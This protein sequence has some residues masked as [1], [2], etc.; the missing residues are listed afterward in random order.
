MKFSGKRILFLGTNVGSVD[1]VKYAKSHGAYT[2]V[3]DYLPEK[4]SE[5]KQICD[6]SYSISTAD[7]EGLLCLARAEKINGVLAGISEFNL[8]QA[9]RL[10]NL[11]DLPFYCNFKQWECVENKKEFRKLCL[12]FNVPTPKTYYTGNSDIEF[13]NLIYPLVVKPVDS[14]ASKGVSICNNRQECAEA[15][16]IAKEISD[17]GSVII[18]EFVKGEEFTAHYFIVDGKSKLISIDNRFPVSVNQ[19]SVTTIPV[20]RLYPSLFLDEYEKQVN[21]KMIDLCDSLCLNVGVLFVQGLYNKES[22]CFYIFEAGLRSAGE[23]P[24]RI[25]EVVNGTNYMHALVDYSLLG[26]VTEYNIRKEDPKLKGKSCAVISFVSKGGRIAKITGVEEISE[27]IPHIISSERRYKEG[28]ITPSGNTLYQIVLRFVLVCDTKKQL[29]DDINQINN[30]VHV[31]GD[32]GSD[33]CLRFDIHS[34]RA[35]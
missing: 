10:C 25:L 18:E 23:A 13:E 11:C 30:S 28:D 22:N 21:E 31:L 1:M 26:K 35:E 33:I 14:G 34:F 29:Y 27:T 5:A 9:M 15:I 16:E 8:L 24:Y 2:I 17:S 7:T 20:A 4:E 6:R 3:A 12:K 19:G 32:D